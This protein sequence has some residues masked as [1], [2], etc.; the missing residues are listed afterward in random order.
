MCKDES[1]VENNSSL[2]RL[3]LE[4]LGSVYHRDVAEV[5]VAYGEHAHED[6]VGSVAVNQHL[7]A[8]LM[9]SCVA[10]PVAGYIQ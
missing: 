9:R 1:V 10:V 5:A 7:C 6:N 3:A 8:A 4:G 2:M